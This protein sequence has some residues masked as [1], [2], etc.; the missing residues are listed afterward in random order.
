MIFTMAK[1]IIWIYASFSVDVWS[2]KKKKKKYSR[3]YYTCNGN[4]EHVQL[5]K[6]YYFFPLS[7]SQGLILQLKL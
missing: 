5:L 4:Y 3:S 7:A 2:T 6:L 1:L